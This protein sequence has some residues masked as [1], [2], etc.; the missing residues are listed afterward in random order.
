MRGS[1]PSSRHQRVVFSLFDDFF[2]WFSWLSADLLSPHVH[3]VYQ[4]F[5][6]TVGSWRK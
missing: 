6:S 1:L 5:K 4:F 2:L 3:L